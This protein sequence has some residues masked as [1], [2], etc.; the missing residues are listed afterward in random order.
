[1]VASP[2]VTKSMEVHY[3]RPISAKIKQITVIAG[4]EGQQGRELTF[5]ADVLRYDG[6]KLAQARSTNILL[7]RHRKEQERKED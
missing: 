5:V 2:S 3:L 4:F 1:M 7:K 6:T